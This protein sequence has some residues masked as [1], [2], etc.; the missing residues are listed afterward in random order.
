MTLGEIIKEYADEH[1]ITSFINDSGLSKAYV[2]MLISNKNNK[3]EPIVPSIETIK[4]VADG[5][6]TSFEEVFNRLDYDFVVKVEGKPSRKR[7]EETTDILMSV[8]KNKDIV[9][10][11]TVAKDSTKEHIR[12][13]IDLL[14]RLKGD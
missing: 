9:E 8:F 11:I 10:L 13:A 7:P 14:K 4:K 3:G 2:Y 6:H 12:I 1:S 5:I